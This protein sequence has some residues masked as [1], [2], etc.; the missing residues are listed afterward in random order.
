MS[1]EGQNTRKK[2]PAQVKNL[3][4]N[5]V[6]VENLDFSTPT[7]KILAVFKPRFRNLC[8]VTLMH[9]LAKLI[10]LITNLLL[11]LASAMW[12]MVKQRIR[13]TS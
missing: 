4:L 6:E 7:K 3:A 5:F 12:I 10:E 8:Q 11:V 13:R 9:I 2:C 1:M